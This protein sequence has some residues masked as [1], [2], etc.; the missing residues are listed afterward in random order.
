VNADASKCNHSSE[1]PP[2][3]KKKHLVGAVAGLVVPLLL[4]GFAGQY[5]LASRVWI[6]LILGCVPYVYL[7]ITSWR[8]WL[9]PDLL[10]IR[11]AKDS[12]IYKRV[13][14]AEW[15]AAGANIIGFVGILL[16]ATGGAESSRPKVRALWWLAAMASGA[17]R[18]MLMQY[19]ED[20]KPL[21]PPVALPSVPSLRLTN[22]IRPVYSKDWDAPAAE[23]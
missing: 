16:F 3:R 12:R 7:G 13:R 6:V 18:V 2:E 17:I 9:Y 23:R 11:W 8:R 15:V 21:E 5:H 20:R 10:P 4:L 1:Q 22:A 19:R 14:A